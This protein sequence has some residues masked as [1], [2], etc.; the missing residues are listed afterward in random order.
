[1]DRGQQRVASAGVSDTFL[2]RYEL[3]GREVDLLL[4]Q[5]QTTQRAV[6]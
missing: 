5:V 6:L 2:A 1:L 4:V 3:E